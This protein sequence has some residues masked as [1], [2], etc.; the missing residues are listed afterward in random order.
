M[1]YYTK[2]FFFFLRNTKNKKIYIYTKNEKADW[3]VCMLVIIIQQQLSRVDYAV[4]YNNNNN[5]RWRSLSVDGRIGDA[6]Q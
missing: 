3:H 5:F 4:D 1:H 2:I 6:E